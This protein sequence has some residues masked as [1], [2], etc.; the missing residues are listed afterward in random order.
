MSQNKQQVLKRLG[1]A[2]DFC[3]C[4]QVKR[5]EMINIAKLEYEYGVIRAIT[6]QF[7]KTQTDIDELG[8]IHFKFGYNDNI[9]T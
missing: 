7:N 1:E 8:S 2:Y 5:Y 4:E 3:L 9:R 6:D